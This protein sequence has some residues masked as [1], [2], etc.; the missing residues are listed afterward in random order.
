MINPAKLLDT[1]GNAQEGA[2]QET[3][4]P[5][6]IDTFMQGS[7]NQESP[8]AGSA[9]SSISPPISLMHDFQQSSTTVPVTLSQLCTP[10]AATASAAAAAA[11]PLGS[12]QILV[13]PNT[14]QHFLVSSAPPPPQPQ[15]I[16][17]PVYYSATP[18]QPVYYH[19]FASGAHGAYVV[20]ATPISSAQSGASHVA[21]QH[22]SLGQ[23]FSSTP[24]PAPATAQSSIGGGFARSLA[25][26]D[27][28]SL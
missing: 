4:L 17:Q 11:T 6:K 14:G 20:A 25:D 10:A 13:D 21:P 24:P 22:M 28:T 1:G 26:F 7:E 3:S 19:A 23:R 16:Y 5:R 12:H 18:A 9:H 2:L 8:G 15:I 27:E